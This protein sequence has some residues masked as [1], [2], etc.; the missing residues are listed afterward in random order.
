MIR[1]PN[2]SNVNALQVFQLMRYS[3]LLLIG[4]MLSKSG[5][6]RTN[7]GHY[8]TFLLIAGAFTF[9]W[10]NGFLKVMMPMSAEKDDK[11]KKELIFNT[12]VLLMLFSVV[13]SVLVYFLSTPFS[14][15]LLNGNEVPLPLL[16]SAYI[17]FN[18]PAMLIEYIYL[19][20]NKP[21]RI[22]TYGIIVFAFQLLAVGVPPIL[23]YGLDIVIKGLIAATLL[24]FI[25]LLLMLTRFSTARFNK[26][27]LKQYISLGAPLVLS[28]LLSSAATYIDGFII[29][30][31]FSPDEFAVFQYGA[32]ELPIALLL[33]NSLSMAM[34]PRFAK[35]D[36]ASPLAEL[37]SE[38][39][40]LHWYLY[41]ISIVLILSSH[42]FF[43]VVFNTQFQ[44]SASIFNIYLLL[45]ISRVLI[46]QTM[47]IA[48]KMNAVIVK[49]SMFELIVNVT[50]SIILV[51][52]IGLQG[53]AWGTF[54]AFLFEK[55]Y[56]V[57][58]CR[59]KLNIKVAE[60]LPL[61]IYIISSLLL[62]FAFILVEFI[63]Y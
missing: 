39:Y 7:I 52:I 28:T 25:W 19:M 26:P 5:L 36:I 16:L 56:L 31:N 3:T 40:R 1:K 54:I 46:P 4:I 45:V 47:L 63:I 20:N 62:I 30:S 18:S 55:V 37:R 23:G 32:R 14:T 41:P 43:P 10:V 58:N 57:I 53:I 33:A 38:V 6:G 50:T 21:G 13:A 15:L 34:L 8:E 61:K 29:T 22:L 35:A 60:Y 11:W 42:W 27:L 12:F 9:F 51:K 44:E 17:L 2:I 48:K 49:A 24:K 59:K